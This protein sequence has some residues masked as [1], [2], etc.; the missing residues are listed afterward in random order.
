VVCHSPVLLLSYEKVLQKWTLKEVLEFVSAARPRASP[1]A[2]FMA[3]LLELDQKLY[4]RQTVKVAF[5]ISILAFWHQ[6]T[7]PLA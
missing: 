6:S 3:R 2:G 4:G 7:L 1:N 5:L